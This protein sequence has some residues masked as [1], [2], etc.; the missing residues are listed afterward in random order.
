[1]D[2]KQ[3]N[4]YHKNAYL[5]SNSLGVTLWPGPL[6]IPYQ[7]SGAGGGRKTTAPGALEAADPR[8]TST[9]DEPITSVEVCVFSR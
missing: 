5:S 3:K 7:L 4:F 6:P 8:S 1:M 2:G 9:S